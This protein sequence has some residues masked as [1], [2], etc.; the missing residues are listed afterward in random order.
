MASHIECRLNKNSLLQCYFLAILPAGRI[1]IYTMFQ[2]DEVDQVQEPSKNDTVDSSTKEN[3]DDSDAE[4][5][6]TH[7]A[8]TAGESEVS[9]DGPGTNPPAAISSPR[10]SPVVLG[11]RLGGSGWSGWSSQFEE[12]QD[13]DEEDAKTPCN[14][15]KENVKSFDSLLLMYGNKTDT[16]SSTSVEASGDRDKSFTF[17]TSVAEKSDDAR[18]TQSANEKKTSERVRFLLT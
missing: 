9:S 14:V 10:D 4:H 16:L 7:S 2:E 15:D 8:S 11:N 3:T 5:K 17:D 12:H 6:S 1:V 18:R 13:E